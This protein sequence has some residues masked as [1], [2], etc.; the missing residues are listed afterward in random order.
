MR[1][2]YLYHNNILLRQP[3]AN[4]FN[5]SLYKNA[6]VFRR[7]RILFFQVTR[8]RPYRDPCTVYTTT[9]II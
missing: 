7:L 1:K 3:E 4:S 9:A 2:L 6:S 8:A 5:V